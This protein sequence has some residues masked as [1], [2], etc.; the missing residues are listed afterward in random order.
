MT[1]RGAVLC[2]DDLGQ[3][4]RRQML[5]ENGGKEDHLSIVKY[6]HIIMAKHFRYVT[7]SEESLP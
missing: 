3:Q 4:E 2:E 1:G 6:P 5:V 7:R